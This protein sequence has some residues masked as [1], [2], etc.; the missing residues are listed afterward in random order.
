MVAINPLSWAQNSDIQNQF[1]LATDDD[2]QSQKTNPKQAG[3]KIPG[4][5]IVVLKEESI[6]RSLTGMSYT[7]GKKKLCKKKHFLF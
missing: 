4:Q 6:S 3:Q 7:N 2:S 5:Y 1:Q